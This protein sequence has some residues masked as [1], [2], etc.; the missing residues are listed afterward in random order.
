VDITKRKRAEEAAKN[1]LKQVRALAARVEAVREEERAHIARMVHDEL[2]QT[3]TGLKLDIS[4]IEKKLSAKDST[5]HMPL[6]LK[7]IQS[8]NALITETV[9]LVNRIVLHLR[10]ALLDDLGL[11]AAI[12]WQVKSFQE[13]SGLRCSFSTNVK[14]RKL[15][16]ELTTALFRILQEAMYNVVRHAHATAVRILLHQKENTVSMKVSDNGRGIT[17][18]ELNNSRDYGLAGMRERAALLGGAVQI[19]GRPGRGTAVVVSIPI[20]KQ[21]SLAKEQ[22]KNW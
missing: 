13:R 10:P 8:M 16:R 7:K 2:G 11:G 14:D 5:L 12:E 15:D 1:S 3:L 19:S 18:S 17:E 20:E 6:I 22:S 21:Q 4:S 9:P